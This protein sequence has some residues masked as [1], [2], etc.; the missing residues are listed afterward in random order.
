MITKQQAYNI[1]R[2][3]INYNDTIFKELSHPI[4]ISVS[5]V[6]IA[7]RFQF[8]HNNADKDEFITDVTVN[9]NGV[10]TRWDRFHIGENDI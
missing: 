8:Y 5:D 9:S 6:P 2:D 10:V 1:A 4:L 3:Y 7:W